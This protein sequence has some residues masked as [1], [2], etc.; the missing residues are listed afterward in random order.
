MTCSYNTITQQPPTHA[1]HAG[2]EVVE[3]NGFTFVRKRKLPDS[4]QQQQDPSPK[5]HQASQ[6]QQQASPVRVAEQP[7]AV[8]DGPAAS[9]CEAGSMEADVPPHPGKGEGQVQVRLLPHSPGPVPHEG[10]A[11]AGTP[12]GAQ[13]LSSLDGAAQ[14][15]APSAAAPKALTAEELCQQLATCL[16]AHCP[17]LVKLQFVVA[18]TLDAAASQVCFH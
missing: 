17:P 3:V 15:D 4:A 2:N 10:A 13:P 11:A 8:A 18:R 7:P 12:H 16:P 5:R 6:Q 9:A 14:P 1:Q